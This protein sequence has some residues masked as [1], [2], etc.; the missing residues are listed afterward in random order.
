MKKV[1]LTR[2]LAWHAE[3]AT[4]AYF[5]LETLPKRWSGPEAV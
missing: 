2:V 1:R 5:D 4:I 3:G